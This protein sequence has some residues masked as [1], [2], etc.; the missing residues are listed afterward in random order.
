M[1]AEA[2]L[3]SSTVIAPE[4]RPLWSKFFRCNINHALDVSSLYTAATLA[5]LSLTAR[6]RLALLKHLFLPKWN[7]LAETLEA[8]KAATATDL[9]TTDSVDVRHFVKAL[10][11]SN[12]DNAYALYRVQ[13]CRLVQGQSKGSISPNPQTRRTQ[14]TPASSHA[15][16]KRSPLKKARRVNARVFNQR[17]VFAQYFGRLVHTKAFDLA[18][19]QLT[20]RNRSVEYIL[21]VTLRIPTAF[22]RMLVARDLGLVLGNRQYRIPRKLVVV[23]GGAAPTFSALREQSPEFR[24]CPTNLSALSVL[25]Q[26]VQTYVDKT[27]I[28]LTCPRGLGIEDIEHFACEWRKWTSTKTS[29]CTRRVYDT[30]GHARRTGYRRAFLMS[31]GQELGFS[32]NQLRNMGVPLDPS[33]EPI[34]RIAP[35]PTATSERDPTPPP[36]DSIPAPAKIL[37]EKTLA[38]TEHQSD[39]AL[40][41]IFLPTVRAFFAERGLRYVKASKFTPANATKLY[42]DARCFCSACAAT[43]ARR[44]TWKCSMSLSTSK[45]KPPG[46]LTIVE[47]QPHAD[48]DGNLRQR[49]IGIPLPMPATVNFD[50]SCD[51]AL[52]PRSNLINV[53]V[54]C[55]LSS[56]LQLLLSSGRIVAFLRSLIEMCESERCTVCLLKRLEHTTSSANQRV[57]AGAFHGML[58]AHDLAITEVQDVFQSFGILLEYAAKETSS[59]HCHRGDFIVNSFQGLVATGQKILTPCRCTNPLV[60]APPQASPTT[61]FTL[62]LSE[63]AYK[64]TNVRELLRAHGY[65]IFSDS[66]PATTSKLRQRTVRCNCGVDLDAEEI[67]TVLRLPD[68]LLIDLIRERQVSATEYTVVKTNIEMDDTLHLSISSG[69]DVYQLTGV[70]LYTGMGQKNGHYYFY[71]RHVSSTQATSWLRYDDLEQAPRAIE[72]LPPAATLHSKILVYTRKSCLNYGTFRTRSAPPMPDFSAPVEISQTQAWSPRTSPHPPAPPA[73]LLSQSPKDQPYDTATVDRHSDNITN[74]HVNKVERTAFTSRL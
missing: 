8:Y 3:R 18:I 73:P 30:K 46:K 34:T 5:D 65:N 32:T 74:V 70:V 47:K 53:G 20:S 71:K 31:C 42:A 15:V 6:L 35:N 43:P 59:F 52:H 37:F 36:D 50:E 64:P 67:L 21:R 68:I 17:Y 24:R 13:L 66:V 4:D 39:D 7:T 49:T 11:Q 29:G 51:T 1:A 57:S 41:A 9:L 12:L 72:V 44:A 54:T 16:P 69:D 60:P 26:K 58:E 40:Q 2:Y 38:S 27:L 28:E 56:A 48:G 55:H 62:Y 22:H 61:A 63:V 45:Q 10:S 25:A 33:K 23:G 19:E 14:R